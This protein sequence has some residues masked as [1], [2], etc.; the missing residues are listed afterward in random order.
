MFGLSRQ[1]RQVILFLISVALVGTG[2]NFF[3]KIYSPLKKVVCFNEEITKVNLNTASL[4]TLISI[5]GI[6][7]KIAVRIIE[8]RKHHSGF[9][10]L[11]ELKVIRGITD[12]RYQKIKDYLIIR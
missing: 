10:N 9:G 7:E 4:D 5:P 6:G 3:I 1:E 11:E 12:Y 8:Y 2:V